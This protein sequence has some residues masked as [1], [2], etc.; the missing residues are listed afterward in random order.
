MY[1]YNSY[2]SSPSYSDAMGFGVFITAIVAALAIGVAAYIIHSLILAKIFQKAGLPAWKAWV[3]YY[4]IWLFF[5]LG[6]YNGALSL[7]SIASFIPWL[8]WIVAIIEF[9][10]M[11]LAANEISKKLDK[12]SSFILF[13]LGI[14]TLGITT[15]VWYCQMAFSKNEWNDSLGKE[16]LAKGTILG[17]AV[18]TE[19][20]VDQEPIAEAE[21]VSE[22]SETTEE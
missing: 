12:A 5:E 21:I 4:N 11:C 19:E 3:P 17:Y 18:E 8:S 15:L 7:L 16:S 20:T 2:Y 13:P 10:F 9:V 22:D 6:G 1:N 14:I